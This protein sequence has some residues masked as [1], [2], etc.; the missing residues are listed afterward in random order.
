MTTTHIRGIHTDGTMTD[1]FDTGLP[2]GTA[3]GQA[4]RTGFTLMKAEGHSLAIN[5]GKLKQVMLGEPGCTSCESGYTDHYGSSACRS[6]SIASGG[7]RAHCTC[8]AC[9]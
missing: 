1:W 9:Y 4:I 5:G 7:K 3:H 2:A 8:R 6:G